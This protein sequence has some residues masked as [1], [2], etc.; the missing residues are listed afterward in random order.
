MLDSPRLDEDRFAPFPEDDVDFAQPDDGLNPRSIE[1]EQALLG[2]CLQD[3]NALDRIAGKID[4]DDFFEEAHRVIYA[5]MR[6]RRDAGGLIDIRLVALALGSVAEADLGGM[7]VHQYV[8]R[9]ATEATTT[10]NAPD[11]AK[12]LRDL[13][14][15]RRSI[16]AAQTL[17]EEAKRGALDPRVI[18]EAAISELDAIAVAREP[19]TERQVSIGEA[20]DAAYD[21]MIEVQAGR[22]KPGITT[23]VRDLDR[24][25]GGGMRSG[26][27]FILAGRPGMGKTT[28]AMSTLIAAARNGNGCYFASLEMNDVQLGERALSAMAFHR[29]RLIP[30]TMIRAGKLSPEEVEVLGDTRGAFRDLPMRIE[31]K[32]GLTIQ[33]IAARARLVA[34]R[35]ASQGRKL[36]LLVIDHLGLVKPSSRYS[37]DRYSEVTELSG[38][39]KALGKELD[40]AMLVLCQLN[41]QVEARTDKRPQLSDLR[42]SGAIEQD[43]DA[44]IFAYREAYYHEQKKPPEEGTEERVAHFERLEQIQNEIELIVAKQRMG[45]TGPVKA[46]CSVACNVVTDAAR[47]LS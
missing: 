25:L 38:T 42:E 37:G 30:Y 20:V 10:F 21:N 34:N 26:E 28:V 47:G 6:K 16:C 22:A 3:P 17:I 4:E 35:F 12:G 40:V 41:R 15:R 9:L 45:K 24:V 8:A 23:G 14:D 43:A 19:A 29:G 2:A 33:Q 36:D 13:A 5:A 32:A 1:M 39:L 11:Y 18:V 31:Q 27:V 44:V 46:F 7:S